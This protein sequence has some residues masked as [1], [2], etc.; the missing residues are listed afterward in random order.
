L[1]SKDWKHPSIVKS[2]KY[3]DILS[4]LGVAHE[5]DGHTYEQVAISI[6]SAL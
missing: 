5:W 2:E 3:F 1:T 4:H 6:N